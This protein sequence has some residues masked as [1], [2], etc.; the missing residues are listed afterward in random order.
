MID[1]TK[2]EA[3]V[4]S[5]SSVVPYDL[6]SSLPMTQW[7]P[8]HHEVLDDKMSDF[9]KGKSLNDAPMFDPFCVDNLDDIMD[10]TDFD[11]EQL[12]YVFDNN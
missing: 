11:V 3:T 4:C 12:M 5:V 1:L 7:N 10:L 8:D 6:A 9:M 2:D